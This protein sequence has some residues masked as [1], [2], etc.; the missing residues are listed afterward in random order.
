MKFWCAILFVTIVIVSNL[1][2]L[3]PLKV[4]ASAVTTQS[5]VRCDRTII[6]SLSTPQAVPI[7]GTL[8]AV[9]NPPNCMRNQTL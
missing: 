8:T 7:G 5:L 2:R 1:A 6:M 3:N 9:Y 4:D